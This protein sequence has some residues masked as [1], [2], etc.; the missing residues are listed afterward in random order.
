MRI[1]PRDEFQNKEFNLKNEF[2]AIIEK[3]TALKNDN[4]EPASPTFRS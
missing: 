1:W 2:L 4:G 3:A